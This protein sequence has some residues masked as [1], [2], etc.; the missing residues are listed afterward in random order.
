M[1]GALRRFRLSPKSTHEARQS[2][3]RLLFA[4]EL[5]M[6]C[7]TTPPLRDISHAV[8]FTQRKR[9]HL[10]L[11]V[12]IAAQA[13]LADV[14]T[15]PTK[16]ILPTH[17]ATPVLIVLICFLRH[18]RLRHQRFPHAPHQ[19]QAYS[20]KLSKSETGKLAFAPPALSLFHL[21]SASC[22]PSS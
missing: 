15:R 4:Q 5:R 3:L 16:A 10:I 14:V 2:H 9:A 19:M 8:I 11:L 12:Y 21:S 1:R 22:I 20:H 7:S 6:L 18:A 17:L 13:Y